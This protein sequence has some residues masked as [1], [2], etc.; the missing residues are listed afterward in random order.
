[1]KTI[2]G[3]NTGCIIG[4]LLNIVLLAA[5]SPATAAALTNADRVLIITQLAIPFLRNATRIYEGLLQMGAD[6]DRLSVVLNRSNANFERIKAEEVEKHFGRPIFAVIPNDYK[7]IG[8]SRDLGH[9]IVSDAPNSP[10]RRAIQEIAR[11]LASKHLSEENL[12][13]S[14]GLFGLFRKRRPKALRNP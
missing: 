10:A 9:P 6:E 7:H 1:M 14:G 12:P 11:R 3:I 2:H 4:G 5:V 8:T 13:T